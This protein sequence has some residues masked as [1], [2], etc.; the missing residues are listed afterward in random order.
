MQLIGSEGSFS[1]GS[2]VQGE[3]M[4]EAVTEL[5][6]Q[7][8]RERAVAL[9]PDDGDDQ[10]ASLAGARGASALR[11]LRHTAGSHGRSARGGP[12]THVV[13]TTGLRSAKAAQGPG[14][15]AQA[16]SRC[17]GVSPGELRQTRWPRR[18][19]LKGFGVGVSAGQL[20]VALM[21]DTA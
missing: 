20:G 1:P 7:G 5:L 10:R 3:E 6:R 2:V 12:N 18:L 19:S 11:R 21:P 17:F 14:D 16:R 9:T 13:T 4:I 8:L 15:L